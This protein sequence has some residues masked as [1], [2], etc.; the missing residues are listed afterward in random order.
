MRAF[1]S[2]VAVY[3]SYYENN[4]FVVTPGR[5]RAEGAEQLNRRWEAVARRRGRGGGGSG[6]DHQAQ[7]ATA[8]L[9]AETGRISPA[10]LCGR[11]QPGGSLRERRGGGIELTVRTQSLKITTREQAKQ[12]SRYLWDG[13]T[14]WQWSVCLSRSHTGRCPRAVRWLKGWNRACQPPQSLL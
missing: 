6:E 14:V 2:Y 9:G 3:V 7:G 13:S 8:L 12:A 10:A 4:G 5:G 11:P 1:I